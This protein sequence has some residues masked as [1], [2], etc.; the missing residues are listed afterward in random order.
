MKILVLAVVLFAFA[1]CKKKDGNNHDDI[2]D[3]NQ[4]MFE[5]AKKGTS[6][7][8]GK[9][10]LIKEE[11]MLE[12][13]IV[14]TPKLR[15]Y[16]NNQRDGKAISAFDAAVSKAWPKSGPYARV[17]YTFARGFSYKSVV[18]QAIAEYNAKTCIRFVPRR[19]SDRSYVEFMHGGGCYSMIGRVGGKQQISLGNGCGTK[20]VAIHEMMHALGFFHEQ[21]RR[22]RDSY[23]TINWNNIPGRVRYNFEKY[24][25]GQAQ[26]LGQPY[27]K[28]SVMHYGNYAFST[29][30]QKT[31]VSKSNPNEVLG[32]R[33]GLST[34]DIRQLKTMYKCG[35]VKPIP[36]QRPPT[37]G[38]CKDK[39]SLC[40]TLAGQGFCRVTFTSWMKNNCKK[41]CK[42]C[43]TKPSL[44]R[45]KP[46]KNSRHCASWAR[47]G[48]CTNR[49]Y[50]SFMAGHCS[51]CK[52]CI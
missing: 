15:K 6:G 1:W 29:N 12:G 14:L 47:S 24:R 22:D 13:D 5:R 3:T 44:P 35:G 4:K 42:K 21:S 51:S 10:K 38:D 19:S 49:R 28:K 20:G 9:K 18:G 36:T 23:I 45:C 27:D 31:I 33:R 34:I 48:Y 39:Y 43:P 17:P 37:T 40:S 46:H 32:Q 8:S 25:H 11:D 16:L 2:L 26:T 50:A 41:S 30:R 52:K 7:F